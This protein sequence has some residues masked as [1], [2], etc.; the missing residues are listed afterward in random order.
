[1]QKCPK[2][3]TILDD[4][5]KQCYMCGTMLKEED[6]NS[7]AEA[8]GLIESTPKK[9]VEKPAPV[10]N[11]F[12]DNTIN[13]FS[14]EINKLNS[15]KNEEIKTDNKAPKEN[16]EKPNK[17]K[18]K[19]NNKE[20]KK[21]NQPVLEK[22]KTTTP[23]EIT[24]P[25]EVIPKTTNNTFFGQNNNSSYQETVRMKPKIEKKDDYKNS[26][27]NIKLE[28]PSKPKIKIK[29][30]QVFNIICVIA[31]VV[32]VVLAA[33]YFFQPKESKNNLGGLIFKVDEKFT[34]ASSDGSNRY[35]KYQDNCS[36]RLMYGQSSGGDDFID[37]YLESQKEEF[38]KEE[39]N[40]TMIEQLSINGNSWKALS[41]IN[42][43][44]T[45]DPNQYDHFIKYK[46]VSIFHNGNFYHTVFV[47]ANND[48][49]CKD[50]Y[51]EFT[52]TLTF[53]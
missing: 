24:P 14:D 3:G 13:F 19:K 27:K 22:D 50:M 37:N 9:T 39:N 17:E 49:T 36:I 30:S 40:Q 8:L 38:E 16:K 28:Q 1:M 6:N 25:K 18:E 29:F 51:D 11:E 52:S 33:K 46:Y 34:L 32:V 31:F 4:S 26:Y 35:Y 2:C 7:F 48:N 42:L 53:E 10:E 15:M 45:E 20:P 47:N 43:V 41:I 23:K 12:S 44:P 21:I 5:K